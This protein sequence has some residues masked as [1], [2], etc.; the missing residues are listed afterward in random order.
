MS[1]VQGRPV[2]RY[3]SII[4]EESDDEMPQYASAG[5]GFTIQDLESK[6]FIRVTPSH[7]CDL[8]SE[9]CGLLF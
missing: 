1:T 4:R 3:G 9:I 6:F 2:N 8:V 7:A 5:I